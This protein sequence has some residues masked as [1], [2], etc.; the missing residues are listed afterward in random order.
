VAEARAEAP[1]AHPRG[2]RL[3]RRRAP[4]RALRQRLDADRGPRRRP[5]SGAWP[6]KRGAIPPAS[7]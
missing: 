3:S 7:R 6:R 5:H 1:S 2:G 4:G